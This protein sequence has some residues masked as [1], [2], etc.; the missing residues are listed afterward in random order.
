MGS[1]YLLASQEKLLSKM[2]VLLWSQGEGLVHCHSSFRTAVARP[3]P[4]SLSEAQDSRAGR[5]PLHKALQEAVQHV[6]AV[7]HEAHILGRAV[8]TLPVQD[9]PLEHVAELLPCTEKVGAHKVHH[10]PVLNEVVLQGV[11]SQHHPATRADVL[12]GL[13]SAGLAVF[14]AVSLVTD[15]HIRARAAQGLLKL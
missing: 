10:A 2:K 5:S 7:A 8:H 9:G 15:H 12:Q 14:D 4:Q 3:P 13:R 11:P 6:A 1:H